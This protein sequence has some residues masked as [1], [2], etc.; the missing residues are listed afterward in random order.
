[1]AY[2][3]VVA[4]RDAMPC[5]VVELKPNIV[6]LARYVVARRARRATF[7]FERSGPIANEPRFRLVNAYRPV[8]NFVGLR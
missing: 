4:I 7:D 3:R 1:M 2:L 5:R 6:T 8:V